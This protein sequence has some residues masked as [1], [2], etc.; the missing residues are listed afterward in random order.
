MIRSTINDE[1]L[2]TSGFLDVSTLG[3]VE[4]EILRYIRNLKIIH[5][6][7]SQNHPWGL[8][9]MQNPKVQPE[10]P[11]QTPKDGFPHPT[12]KKVIIMHKVNVLKALN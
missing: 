1:F 12:L 9:K 7:Y 4:G 2:R 11:D 5:G 10:L 8:Y 6:H 3:Q